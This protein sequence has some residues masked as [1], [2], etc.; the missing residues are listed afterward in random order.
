MKLEVQHHS[1]QDCMNLHDT[2]KQDGSIHK[3]DITILFSKFNISNSYIEQGIVLITSS[4]L[5][6]LLEIK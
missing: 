3:D 1:V 2:H 6:Q 4:R 5:S